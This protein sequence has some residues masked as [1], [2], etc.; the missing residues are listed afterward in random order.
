MPTRSALSAAI[1]TALPRLLALALPL[2]GAAHAQVPDADAAAALQGYFSQCHAVHVCNGSVLVARD[3][4]VLYAAAFGD[5]GAAGQGPLTTAHAFDIGS[6]SKQFTAAAILRL[7]ERGKLRVDDAVADHLPGFPYPRMTLRQLL[8]HTSGVPDV[9]AY[10][11]QVL[12]GGKFAAPLMADDA[13]QVLAASGTVPKSAPGER[14]EYS[15]TGYLL[16]AQVVAQVS[17][18]PFASFLQREFFDPLGMSHTRVRMPANEAAIAP[19][20]YGFT[21]TSDG[22]RRAQ[23]QIPGFYML[24]AGG[25]YSTAG[26][27]LLWSKALRDGKAMSVSSW[28]EATTALRLNDGS[29]VPYG[30]GLGLRVS[31]LQQPRIE[32]GGHWRAFKADL[33]RFPAQD[34][35]VVLL[36][37]NGED[38]SVDAARDAVEAILAGKPYSPVKEPIDW[39]LR[40]RL[41]RDDAAT[42]RRWLDAQRTAKPARYDVPEDKLN[43]IGYR[44]IEAKQVDK[45]LAVMRFNQETHPAS[46]NALDSLADAYL[47]AGDRDAAIAQAKRMLELKPD[48]RAAQEKLKGL[49]EDK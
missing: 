33:A 30:F 35:D 36:T 29:S 12:R 42:L 2:A 11:T 25:I 8:T 26:D 24:G 17:G 5:A 43:D 39:P 10:Y 4:K 23:D 22:Q 1:R 28:R 41:Q 16:L 40:E 9:M 18:L 27:L 7:A 21:P 6:I 19:R 14:F 45:A 37:N 31:P 38:D 20:A 47:A 49:V 3:G 15:N 32:H 44:L 34:I 48:S 13:V 46:M